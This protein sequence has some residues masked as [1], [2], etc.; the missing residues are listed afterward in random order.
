MFFIY[1]LHRWT[2]YWSSDPRLRVDDGN[3]LQNNLK[4]IY[5]Y[6]KFSYNGLFKFNL[7]FEENK[8]GTSD[9]YPNVMCTS[10]S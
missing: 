1:V 5:M 3:E 8:A 10:K 7:N 4:F 9:Q 6:N 2:G